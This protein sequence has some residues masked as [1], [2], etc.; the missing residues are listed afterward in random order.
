MLKYSYYRITVYHGITHRVSYGDPNLKKSRL[1]S[2][3]LVYY[4]YVRYYRGKCWDLIIGYCLIF[5]WLLCFMCRYFIVCM[6]VFFVC[7]S[8]CWCIC[9]HVCV[10]SVIV[11]AFMCVCIMY[12]YIF[13]LYRNLWMCMCASVWIIFFILHSIFYSMISISE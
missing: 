1:D 9:V 13:Y 3:F 11:Y 8:L 2:Y 7:V 12:I 10:C 4:V 6:W 5:C